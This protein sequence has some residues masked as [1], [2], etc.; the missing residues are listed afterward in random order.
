M[1]QIFSK[2]LISLFQNSAKSSHYPDP[3]KKF[4]IPVDE[5]NAKQL[6][7]NCCP[8]SLLP[9]FCKIFEKIISIG[10]ITVFK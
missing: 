8:I 2:P 1:G 10:F 7:P 9:I 5:K 4:I 6:V 3:W